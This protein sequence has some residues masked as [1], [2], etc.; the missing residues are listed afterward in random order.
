[1]IIGLFVFLSVSAVTDPSARMTRLHWLTGGWYIVCILRFIFFRRFGWALLS[2]SGQ[3]WV[4]SSVF[5]VA[6]Q[7]I[8]TDERMLIGIFVTRSNAEIDEIKEHYK[9]RR[10]HRVT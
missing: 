5:F 9:R 4:S 2:D 10:Y 8:G 6:F 1:M 3:F 7:G